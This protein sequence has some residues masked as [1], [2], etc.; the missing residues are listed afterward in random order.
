MA[1]TKHQF[2]FYDCDALVLAAKKLKALSSLPSLITVGVELPK[3]VDLSLLERYFHANKAATGLKQVDIVKHD[4]VLHDVEALISAGKTLKTMQTAL[5]KAKQDVDAI[6]ELLNEKKARLRQLEQ[7]LG[8]C[9][10]CKQ[11]FGQHAH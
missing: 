5:D 11:S 9:P 10:L 6:K 3:I 4:I 1:V 7:E 8:T 2:Q